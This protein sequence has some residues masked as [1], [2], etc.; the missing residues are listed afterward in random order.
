[1][2]GVG[3]SWAGLG[4]G[5]PDGPS[6]RRL[7]WPGEGRA[8][9]ARSRPCIRPPAR[10][11]SAS[12]PV[13]APWRPTARSLSAFHLSQAGS[14][15]FRATPRPPPRCHGRC[16]PHGPAVSDPQPGADPHLARSS[17]AWGCQLH[18][19][20]GQPP[21]GFPSKGAA[22][23][24]RVFLDPKLLW[25][26]GLPQQLRSVSPLPS[27]P[28]RPALRVSAPR[29]L[30]DVQ[31]F[32]PPPRSPPRSPFLSLSRFLYRCNSCA[33]VATRSRKTLGSRVQESRDLALSS[34][35]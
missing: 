13:S 26:Q 23:R 31:Y 29:S 33:H 27:P 15:T 20:A 1:M 9:P 21:S 25:D 19:P 30:Y 4:L 24:G 3:C 17:P 10:F 7:A 14:A 16:V 5:V 6:A 28:T 2:R 8:G 32:L 34:L 35:M 11:L 18:P 12:R 22:G